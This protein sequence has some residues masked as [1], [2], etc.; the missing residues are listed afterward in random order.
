MDESGVSGG[1]EYQSKIMVADKSDRNLV[2]MIETA[3]GC[4][5]HGEQWVYWIGV[6]VWCYVETGIR[7]AYATN[8]RLTS[9]WL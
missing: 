9:V 1:Q 7:A 3:V 4:T 2:S 8:E 6:C 5:K